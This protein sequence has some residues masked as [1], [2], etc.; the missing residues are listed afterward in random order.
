GSGDDWTPG[1][2]K[3]GAVWCAQK[4]PNGHVGVS[5]NRSRIGKIDLN[6]TDFFMG[7]PKATSDSTL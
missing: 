7:S 3:P 2:G 6:N 5:A 1:S 4:I